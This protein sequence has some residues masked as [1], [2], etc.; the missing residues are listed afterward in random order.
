M[1]ESFTV[2][3]NLTSFQIVNLVSGL[4]YFLF[5]RFFLFCFFSVSSFLLSF[6]QEDDFFSLVASLISAISYFSA[7]FSDVSLSIGRNPCKP[8][9]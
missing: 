1:S 9:L 4:S 7:S 3:D 5:F 6:F 8:F 2:E